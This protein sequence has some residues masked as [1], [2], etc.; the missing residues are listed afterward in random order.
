MV[1]LGRLST[2]RST[3]QDMSETLYSPDWYRVAQLR[4]R[5][6]A[7]AQMHR[8]AYRDAVWYVLEDTASGRC[9]RLSAGAYGLVGMLDG[10][11]SVQQIWDAAQARDGEDAP[12]QQETIRLLGQL[13]AAD[14]LVADLPPDSAEIAERHDR[15][16]RRQLRQ[17]LAQPL[18]VR[19]PLWDPDAF[20]TRWL[21]LVRPLF[22]WVGLLLWLAVVATGAVLAA[23]H[24]SALTGNLVDRV[25]SAQNLLLLWLAYPLVKAVHELGHGFAAKRWGGE[26]HEIGIMFLVLMPVPYVEASSASAFPDKYQRMVVGAIGIMVELCLAAL[27]LF[28]WL[29]MEPGVARALAFN[30]M[31][32]GGVSTLFFNGNPLLRFD[33]YYVLADWLEIPNLATRAQQYLGWLTQHHLFGA[34]DLEPPHTAP[35]ERGWLVFYGIASFLYRQFILFAIVLF[36]AGQFF[37]L[38]V[39]LA[40]WAVTQ[41]LL[42]PLVKGLHFVLTNP[43]L[44]R[45]RARAVLVTASLAAALL[46]VIAVVPVPSWT[47][48]EGVVQLPEEARLRVQAAGTVTRLLAADGSRV[49]AGQPL[50]A[51]A[52]P[53]LDAEVALLQARLRELDA[54]LTAAQVTDRSRTRV[55]HEEIAQARRDLERAQEKQAGLV[56]KSPAAGQL[57]LPDAADLP[58]RHLQRGAL[59]GYVT[60]P[61]RAEIRAVVDEDRI[62]LVRERTDAVSVRL[63][64]W[65]AQPAASRILRQV[66][67]ATKDLPA[68]ALGSGGG[69]PVA[70]D[71]MDPNGRRALAP[72]FVLDLAL[73]PALAAEARPGQRVA[74]RL[75]HGA[76]PLSVQWY[77]A[78]RQL[79]LSHFQV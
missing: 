54:R 5:L 45:R 61:G 18:A 15:Q 55:L 47:R 79:F 44:D 19:I 30:V 39:L 49:Q 9:H 1:G 11:R 56:L 71:P 77:R 64:C 6:R 72:V 14:L 41:Q 38:G 10:V 4:P 63:R 57:V 32:I 42:W 62:G 25:L 16:Q 70:L 73:P 59:V 53:Y 36:I 43:K 8:H 46:A 60:A 51:L 74:V 69:G 17:R 22:S 7:H 27:A 12:T 65:A 66:P 3:I 31:L 52:D 67:A 33:G 50:L 20:L 40:I 29:A 21:W 75:D 23:S 26:V 76:E 48:T 78:L 13:H 34:R 58:G 24:W 28:L 35:G 2:H 37:V 68:A